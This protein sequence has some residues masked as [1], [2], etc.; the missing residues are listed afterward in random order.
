MNKPIAALK[1]TA[2]DKLRFIEMMAAD[3]T[4]TP[5]EVRCGILLL[6]LYNEGKGAAWPSYVKIGQMLGVSEKSAI[7]I[8]ASLVR[9][10]YFDMQ[11]SAGGKGHS[12]RYTPRWQTLKP[13]SGFCALLRTLNTEARFRVSPSQ[14]LKSDAPNPEV[15]PPQTLK[16]ASVD[17]SESH[18]RE[19]PLSPRAGRASAPSA[20]LALPGTQGAT[21]TRARAREGSGFAAD[22][23]GEWSRSRCVR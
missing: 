11:Q 8:V 7:T 5:S 2:L 21:Q 6:E 15:R 3:P 12:N 20:P 16:S 22:A 18:H 14:T 19:E 10:G 4:L 17:S 13:G 9:K 23:F 1:R